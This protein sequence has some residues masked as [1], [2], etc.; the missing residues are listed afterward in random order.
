MNIVELWEGSRCPEDI[1]I[2]KNMQLHLIK[3]L[4]LKAA[5]KV[6]QYSIKVLQST[7]HS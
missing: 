6:I 3:L 7:G 1:Q 2:E 4:S 5:P